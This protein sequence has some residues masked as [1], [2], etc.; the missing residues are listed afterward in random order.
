MKKNVCFLCDG[1]FEFEKWYGKCE[2]CKILR[3]E[4]KEHVL[5]EMGNL[6][7]LREKMRDHLHNL[8]QKQISTP[9]EM[10][11]QEKEEYDI[12]TKHNTLYN[13]IGVFI[14]R[15]DRKEI[16]ICEIYPRLYSYVKIADK[17]KQIYQ[18]DAQN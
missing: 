15:Y 7:A 10:T 2:H 12:W 8:E 13:E 9:D 1:E 6:L 3:P 14:N 5:A 4:S 16:R 11:K 17:I 18:C